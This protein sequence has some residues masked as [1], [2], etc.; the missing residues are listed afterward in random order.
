MQK[1]GTDTKRGFTTAEKWIIWGVFCL[2]VSLS[3]Y[4]VSVFAGL[5]LF[6][7]GFS[8]LLKKQRPFIGGALSL[9][10]L[11]ILVFSKYLI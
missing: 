4:R 6:S 2:L 11:L 7:G 5:L 1:S 10:G 3:T 9:T 8:L